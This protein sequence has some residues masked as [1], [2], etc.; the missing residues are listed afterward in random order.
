M[1]AIHCLLQSQRTSSRK[2]TYRPPDGSDGNDDDEFP[3]MPDL[4][5]YELEFDEDG[6]ADEEDDDFE[7]FESSSATASD[8]RRKGPRGCVS[9][10]KQRINKVER[11]ARALNYQL[12]YFFTE[13]VIYFVGGFAMMAKGGH[14]AT[15]DLDLEVSESK[16][17]KA[18]EVKVE[19]GGFKINQTSENGFDAVDKT[20]G[21]TINARATAFPGVVPL[22]EKQGGY[23]VVCDDVQIVEKLNALPNRRDITKQRTDIEDIDFLL[24]RGLPSIRDEVAEFFDT[25]TLLKAVNNGKLLLQGR[26]SRLFKP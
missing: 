20:T 3:D 25:D 21:I 7:S 26:L 17:L 6:D 13:G 12:K 14:R 4:S 10:T 9:D 8:Q 19:S 24:R 22:P 18:I 5:G 11:V 15:T 16:Y 2:I 1:K 23:T